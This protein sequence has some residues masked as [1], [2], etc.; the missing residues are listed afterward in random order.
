MDKQLLP[1]ARAVQDFK[2]KCMDRHLEAK[3]DD[4]DEEK[5]ALEKF[6][7]DFHEDVIQPFLTILNPSLDL[8]SQGVGPWIKNIINSMASALFTGATTGLAEGQPSAER[9]E[10]VL[11]GYDFLR[12]PEDTL[13]FLDQN[14]VG[15]HKASCSHGLTRDCIDFKKLSPGKIYNQ[16]PVVGRTHV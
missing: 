2:G 7:R 15:K 3:A 16:K 14:M 8:E 10:T 9:I 13:R 1:L 6:Y 11:Y 5:S 12:Q 4:P